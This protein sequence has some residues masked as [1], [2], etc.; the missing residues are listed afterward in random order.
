M[1]EE[2]QERIKYIRALEKFATS[3]A[4]MLK[5]SDFEP[6]LFK[7]HIEKSCKILQKIKPIA[8]TQPYAKNLQKF[9]NLAINSS[10]KDEILKEFNQ[11]EK[12][13]NS[14][15]YKKTKHKKS[16]IDEY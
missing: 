6:N 15:T 16:V 10:N 1:N 14:K 13:K 7:K 12:L 8:L 11:L 3:C 4:K 5:R 9:A 2:K